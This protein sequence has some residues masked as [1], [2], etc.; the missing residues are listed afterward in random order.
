MR[1]E[2]SYLTGAAVAL[3]LVVT[4]FLSPPFVIWGFVRLGPR[5]SMEPMVRNSFDAF[6]R[7]AFWLMDHCR[8]YEDLLLAEAKLIGLPDLP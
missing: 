7:P 3:L 2:V 6:Y 1:R 4:Y 5:F 8:L